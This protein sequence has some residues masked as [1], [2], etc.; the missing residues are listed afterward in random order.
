MLPAVAAI[1]AI[2]ILPAHASVIGT[3]PAAGDF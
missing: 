2:L 1:A 3:T